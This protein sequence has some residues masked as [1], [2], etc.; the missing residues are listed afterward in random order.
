MQIFHLLPY[1]S[2]LSAI[3]LILMLLGGN[4]SAALPAECAAAQMG[5]TRLCV[6]TTRV[7][8]YAYLAQDLGSPIFDTGSDGN[9]GSVTEALADYVHAYFGPDICTY[10]APQTSG[11]TPFD[12]NES[13]ATY[14]ATVTI[15]ADGG[16]CLK[17]IAHGVNI[18]FLVSDRCPGGWERAQ[19]DDGTFYCREPLWDR[20]DR[21]KNLGAPCVREGNPCNVATGNKFQAEVDYTA[22]NVGRLEYIRYYNS[23]TGAWTNTYSSNISRIVSSSPATPSVVSTQRADGRVIKFREN[24]VGDFTADLDINERLSVIRDASKTITGWKLKTES[25]GIEEYDA[26]GHLISLQDRAGLK[27][28]LSYESIGGRQILKSVNDAFGRKLVFMND[29]TG[30]LKTLIDPVSNVTEYGYDTN[31]RLSTVTYPGNRVRTYLYNE[32]AFT[33]GTNQPNALT[34]IIDENRVRFATWNYDAGGNAISSEHANGLEKVTL[35]YVKDAHGEPS[36]TSVTDANGYVRTYKL[37]VSNQVPK[38]QSLDTTCDTCVDDALERV[39]DDNGNL[40]ERV[41]REGRRTLVSYDLTRNLPLTSTF[42]DRTTEIDWHPTFRLPVE[43]R[44]PNRT[45]TYDYD[46]VTGAQV[47][48][49]VTDTN[50]KLSRVT[51]YTPDSKGLIKRIDGP[52]TD[53]SDFTDFTYD[54]EGN[55]KTIKNALGHITEFTS[56]DK[57]GRVLSMKDPNGLVTLLTYDGRGNLKTRKEG[58]ELTAFGYDNVG[59]LI[60]MTLPSTEVITYTYDSGHRLTDIKNSAGELIH[61]TIDKF[62]NQ[63]KRE[64]FDAGGKLTASTGAVFDRFNRLQKRVQASGQETRFETDS[65]GVLKSITDPLARQTVLTRDDFGRIE[66]ITQADQSS[67]KQEFDENDQLRRVTTPKNS[68]VAYTV[69]SLGDV[70]LVETG[71]PD[72]SARTRDFDGAGNL[73]LKKDFRGSKTALTYDALNR[74]STISAAGSTTITFGYDAGAYGKGRLT[75]IVDESGTS[76]RTYNAQGRVETVSRAFSGLTITTRYGYDSA[77]RL[78]TVTYPSGRT[79][80]YRYVKERVVGVELGTAIVASQITYEPFAGV[81]SWRWGNNQEYLRTTDLDGRL[82]TYSLGSSRREIK[83]DDFGHIMA[84]NDAV[85]PSLTQRYEYDKLDR[86][87][88]Y[89]VGSSATPLEHFDYD[90][91]GN[92]T[93]AAIAGK[94]FTYGYLPE[95]D[96]LLSVSGPIARQWQS[97]PTGSVISDGLRT[98]TLDGF[99]RFSSVTTGSVRTDYLRNGLQQR[100]TKRATDGSATHFVF[101]E[102]GKLLAELDKSGKTLVEHIWLGDQP[103]AVAYGGTLYY[104]FSD[105]LNTPRL[106][107]DTANRP[108]WSWQSNPF[109][110]T[111]PNNNPTGLGTITYNPRFPGQYYDAESGLHH[112][113][114]RDYDPQSGR[115]IQSDPIGLRG[116]LNTY[117]YVGNNPVMRSDAVGLCPFCFGIMLFVGENAVAF[118]AATIIGVSAAT[119]AYIPSPLSGLGLE[120]RNGAIAARTIAQEAGVIRAFVSW[121][122]AKNALGSTKANPIHHIV[123][124]CQAGRSGFSL[125]RLNSTDNLTRLTKAQHDVISAYYSSKPLGFPAKVRDTLNGKSFEEQ[126]D[127]GLE[128]VDKVLRGEA[129]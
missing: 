44:E 117:N 79:L 107:T 77:G 10:T 29:S 21:D 46:G 101:D 2:L 27:Q 112:N 1:R 83:R 72:D 47:R 50:E 8:R 43:V 95:S 115:Y 15:K 13:W 102:E 108:R 92:R 64:V 111:Q 100:V 59:Q 20:I 76:T 54:A 63:T 87:T 73:K 99:R 127:F 110:S 42:S 80:T 71:D 56:Y 122:A 58:Q 66:E 121:A 55:L 57:N 23:F 40:A 7:E 94:T 67:I 90:K 16:Q 60:T 123:E 97:D 38:V 11:W 62:G 4:A 26:V 36:E 65:N 125:T 85:D 128:V 126:L 3:A 22:P 82:S 70:K 75:S 86:V 84:V 89:F 103:I 6:G 52:R 118:E 88:D 61:F 14:T 53:V 33:A 104:V 96:F 30:R 34:G 106:I 28:T 18:G 39:Y 45:T 93:A 32:P 129:L 74:I 69:N 24:E 68:S 35:K 25:D 81:K 12:N 114:Y 109:G 37:V 9:F 19:S 119:G 5:G 51:T 17:Q 78:T 41:D 120:A 113:Y 48:T 98:Y 124:Q 91:N 105:Q 49:T 116:G 31:G